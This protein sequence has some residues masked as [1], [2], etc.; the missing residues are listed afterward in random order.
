MEILYT[1]NKWTPGDLAVWILLCEDVFHGLPG[2]S[3]VIQYL[4]P[5]SRDI[6]LR[7][8]VNMVSTLQVFLHV[9]SLESS[10]K[11]DI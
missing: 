9:A 4:W 1:I 5:R 7:N 6:C 8:D 3:G 10:V 2:W 11:P